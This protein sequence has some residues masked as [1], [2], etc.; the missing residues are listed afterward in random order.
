MYY[1]K[2]KIASGYF[3]QPF[4]G[5]ITKRGSGYS[6]LPFGGGFR[7]RKDGK[8]RY[9]Y[10]YHYNKSGSGIG[11]WAKKAFD[12]GKKKASEYVKKNG[13]E[14]LHK[15]IEK[16]KNFAHDK[17]DKHIKNESIKKT[18]KDGVNTASKAG[19]AKVKEVTTKVGNTINPG[20]ETKAERRAERRRERKRK[21]TNDPIG[22]ASKMQKPAIDETRGGRIRRRRKRGR[23]ARGRGLSLLNSTLPS[24]RLL[25]RSAAAIPS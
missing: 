18:L 2:P 16:V 15:G 21:G 12:W 24:S 7:R 23:R 4:G 1:G 9:H 11:D 14:L 5:R 13:K 10:Y 25:N 6:P 22:D 17:I 3:P 19:H 8:K 20:S